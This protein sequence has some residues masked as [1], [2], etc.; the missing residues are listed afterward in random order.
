MNKNQIKKLSNEELL[1]LEHDTEVDCICDL[2]L[3]SKLYKL[4]DNLIK[5]INIRKIKRL[6]RLNGFD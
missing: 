2:S 5:E 1:K 6:P 4:H 3:N